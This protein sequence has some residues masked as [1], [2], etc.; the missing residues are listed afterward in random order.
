MRDPPP[1]GVDP[2]VVKRQGSAVRDAFDDGDLLRVLPAVRVP[3]DRQ[4]P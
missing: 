4:N 3:A 1:L 2:G